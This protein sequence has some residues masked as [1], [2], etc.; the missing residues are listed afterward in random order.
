MWSHLKNNNNNKAIFFTDNQNSRVLSCKALSLSSFFTKW[1]ASL[2]SAI[3]LR[4]ASS[5]LMQT[6]SFSRYA[7]W[8]L[9]PALSRSA[10]QMLIEGK[11]CGKTRRSFHNA[12]V[13]L[14]SV[15]LTP[16]TGHGQFRKLELLFFTHYFLSKFLL[17]QSNFSA[18]AW[19][20]PVLCLLPVTL[21]SAFCWNALSSTSRRKTVVCGFRLCVCSV[22]VCCFF[23]STRLVSRRCFSARKSL[24]FCRRVNRSDGMLRDF[25][26]S[27][28]LHSLCSLSPKPIV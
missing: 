28:G 3:I 6:V 13:L 12:S 2:S 27:Y 20:P 21:P 9:Q 5:E 17:V 19:C 4:M 16:S 26:Q 14:V 24:Q 1:W 15:W 7:G 25:G 11:G 23:C 10:C 8:G 22:L 18:S